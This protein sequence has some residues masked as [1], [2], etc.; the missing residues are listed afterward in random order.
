MEE[1]SAAR[2]VASLRARLAEAEE[3]LAAARAGSSRDANIR[4]LSKE[5]R[6]RVMQIL[7]AAHE[8]YAAAR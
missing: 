3:Q 5:A 2:N 1:V 8:G 6:G 7:S 4:R